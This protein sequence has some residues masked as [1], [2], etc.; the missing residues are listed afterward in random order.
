MI[1]KRA[2]V[3]GRCMGVRRAVGLALRTAEAERKAG[4]RVYTLGPLIHN[5]QA[6]AD[7]ESRGIHALMQDGE[8][9]LRHAVVIIRAHGVPPELRASFEARG[10]EI[11]DA[12]CPR[13]IA[14]Q[15][16]AEDYARRGYQVVIAGDRD[17]G[18]V[19]GLVGYA[20]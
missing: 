20:Q 8:G 18:E 3:L 7:L 6:V 16:R 12:T 4:R 9:E 2:A 1:V 15:R 11:V 10:A 19:A 14:S 17:H 13:V 5:P